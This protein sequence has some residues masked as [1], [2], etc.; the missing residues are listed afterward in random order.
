M[1]HV[2]KALDTVRLA[3]TEPGVKG[4]ADLAAR[5]DV[6]PDVARRMLKKTPAAIRNLSKLEAVAAEILGE[7]AL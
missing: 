2:Q 1:S 6:H 5:A 3:S 7:R 4:V